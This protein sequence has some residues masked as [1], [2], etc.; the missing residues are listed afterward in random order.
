MFEHDLSSETKIASHRF[1]WNEST[2]VMAKLLEQPV[3]SLPK[4]PT[5]KNPVNNPEIESE[6][7]SN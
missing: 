2:E 3:I 6:K 1:L 7:G 5:R 4:V